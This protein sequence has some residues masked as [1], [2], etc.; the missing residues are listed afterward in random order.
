MGLLVHIELMEPMELMNSK[1]LDFSSRPFVDL[2]EKFS[3]PEDLPPKNS[4]VGST[5]PF[6]TLVSCLCELLQRGGNFSF[7]RRYWGGL[8]SRI[9]G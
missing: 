2:G 7:V 5:V 4:K 1:R 6:M 9:F 3:F 8:F